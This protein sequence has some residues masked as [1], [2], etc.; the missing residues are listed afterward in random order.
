MLEPRRILQD[1]IVGTANA[2]EWFAAARTAGQLDIALDCAQNGQVNPGTLATAAHDT[3]Q[4]APEFSFAVAL[5]ALDLFLSGYGYD[6]RWLEMLKAAEARA[7]ASK[8]LGNPPSCLAQVQSLV[9]RVWGSQ[10]P[11][12]KPLRQHLERNWPGL[13]WSN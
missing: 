1:L 8:A 6:D 2:G 9:P 13:H 10:D 3:I 5:R 4:S 12:A 11:L 7:G